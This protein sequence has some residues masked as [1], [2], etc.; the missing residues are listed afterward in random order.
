[1][2]GILQDELM[3]LG[4]QQVEPSGSS[5]VHFGVTDFSIALRVLL[6]T[7][8]A[9]KVME[10]LAST[11]DPVYTRQDIYQFVR[12]T[13]PVQDLLG[14]SSSDASSSSPPWLTLSV[15][16]TLNNARYIPT[17]INHSH[18]TALNVKNALVDAARDSC[19]LDSRPTVDTVDPDVPL[20]VVL[21]GLP[22]PALSTTARTD[23]SW[24]NERSRHDVLTRA[25]WDNT[26]ATTHAT[27]E[28]QLSSGG[29][30]LS[31]YRCL[32]AGSLHRRGYRYDTAMHKAALK[33]S[34]AAGLLMSAGWAVAS[35]QPQSNAILVDPMMGS[36][37]FLVE[38]AMM[39]ADLAPGL[40]RIK[41]Q[42]PSS[43][44]P[45]IVRWKHE[46]DTADEV[47]TQWNDL[48][49]DAT[50]RAQAGLARLA[51]D[52]V[53]II[54]NDIH[55]GACDLAESALS[56][57]G[58]SKVVQIHRH[59]CSEWTPFQD[60]TL[61][62]DTPWTIVSNPPW[63]VRLDD[64]VSSSWEALR[65]FLRQRCPAD[66]QAWILSGSPTATKHL[67]LRRSQSLPLQTGDQD[68]RWLQYLIRPKDNATAVLGD[69]VEDRRLY[70]TLSSTK[71][72]DATRQ[73]QTTRERPTRPKVRK[74]PEKNEWLI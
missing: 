72:G 35:R 61:A 17:D 36:G 45:P 11:S 58:L 37:T 39:A 74:V 73:L 9:H 15:A 23:Y 27:G 5:A 43:Y 66:S 41:C 16:V 42:V 50:T 2:A 70:H 60:H 1:M 24:N 20:V 59:N 68:L 46:T 57:A 48:L 6:W 29:A 22:P 67:G 51:R 49:K 62:H 52:N 25:S 12:R 32:H 4:C 10:L 28:Q 54:G 53:R 65:I 40:M 14:S 8:T 34:T 47:V 31:L 64:D 18:Y 63:G 7:R 3:A 44:R 13:V 26:P 19:P 56:Q 30:H 71:Q 69:S 21:R 55:G 33:E 38:G